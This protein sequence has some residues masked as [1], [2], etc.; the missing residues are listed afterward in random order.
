M[1]DYMTLLGAEDVRSAG[2]QMQQAA[3]EMSTAAETIRWAL[4]QHQQFMNQ[5]LADYRDIRA[6]QEDAP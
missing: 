4:E 3:H 5:W 1:S 6:Q 2:R